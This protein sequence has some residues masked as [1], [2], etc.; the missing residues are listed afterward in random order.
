[1]F[2]SPGADKQ[3]NINVTEVKQPLAGGRS[4]Q[5]AFTKGSL[6]PLGTRLPVFLGQSLGIGDQRPGRKSYPSLR[7]EKGK[8]RGSMGEKWAGGYPSPHGPSLHRVGG[9][10]PRFIKPR[11]HLASLRLLDANGDIPCSCRRPFQAARTGGRTPLRPWSDVPARTHLLGHPG[12][13][14][15]LVTPGEV[16]LFLPG[17]LQSN[18]PLNPSYPDPKPRHPACSQTT[19]LEHQS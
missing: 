18:C 8:G 16:P 1:M 19:R 6:P 11:L 13:F 9:E 10:T 12:P 14:N 2:Y 17:M 5:D 15:R 7:M 4:A 3:I